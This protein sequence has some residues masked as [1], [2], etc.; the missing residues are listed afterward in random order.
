MW[1]SLCLYCCLVIFI[2][3]EKE[4]THKHTHTHIVD[5]QDGLPGKT[6]NHLWKT[7]LQMGKAP[8]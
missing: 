5:W 4:N 7:T 2:F 8:V 3:P 6:A 1:V